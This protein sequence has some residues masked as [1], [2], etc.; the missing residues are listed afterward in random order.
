MKPIY[1]DNNSTTAIHP[2]VREKMLPFLA[3]EYGNP[4]STS[5][6]LG[7]NAKQA[8]NEARENL[9][10]FL[11]CKVDEVVFTSCG[12][13]SCF[14][15][16]VGAYLA[17]PEKNHFIISAVEHPA[18]I[19]AAKFLMDNFKA[20]IT[21]IPVDKDGIIDVSQ[22]ENAICK[23]TN[24]IS[25]MYANNETGIIS[26]LSEII[27]IA[28]KQNILVHTDATQG[29]GKALLS[30]DKLGVDYLSLSGHKFH[31]PKGIGAL[32]I[33]KDAPW[34]T[35]IKGGGQEDGRRGGTEAVPYI[36]AIGE[37]A[38]LAKVSLKQESIS[39]CEELRDYFESKLIELFPS[40]FIQGKSTNRL[41]NTS[42]FSLK[43]TI[44]SEI[45]EKL[46]LEGLVISAGS[47]CKSAS[48]KPSHVLTAMGLTLTEAIA[49]FRVSLNLETTKS[50]I[51]SALNIFQKVVENTIRNNEVELENS[52]QKVAKPN[53]I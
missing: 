40:V 50:E 9:A 13:E 27:A 51:D 47:A 46:A 49:S 41:P 29:V 10:D 22:L 32:L 14:F 44:A 23:S 24:L 11:N 43:N 4:S 18:V 53:G 30:F 26:P 17:R 7:Q 36:A 8:V 34:K 3:E 6:T 48:L 12:T 37:A 45:I 25:I 16:L 33:K 20:S 15:A 21:T 1:L 2:Q 39:K 5:N 52:L 38:R 19:E 31:A 42:N 35:I 28:K